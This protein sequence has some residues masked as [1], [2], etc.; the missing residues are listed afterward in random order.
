MARK[1]RTVTVVTKERVTIPEDFKLS[2]AT[3]KF[4]DVARGFGA[5]I[6]PGSAEARA[7][8][9]YM[10]S[11][12]RYEES[13]AYWQSLGDN[14]K[15]MA[16]FFNVGEEVGRRQNGLFRAYDSWQ[17]TSKRTMHVPAEEVAQIVYDALMSNVE[18]M[19]DEYARLDPLARGR[20]FKRVASDLIALFQDDR[21]QV[22]EE[23]MNAPYCDDCR[24][25]FGG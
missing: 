22:V 9:G 24:E 12:I 17:A 18:S 3:R 19:P 4:L 10:R 1:S 15:D 21:V 6:E 8:D 23:N 7:F 14:P 13:L 16:H 5:D 2:K 25:S 20:E 11:L